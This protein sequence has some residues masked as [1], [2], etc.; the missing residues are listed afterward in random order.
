MNILI[1]AQ[2]QQRRLSGLTHPKHLLEVGGEPILM[3]TL[4]M[5]FDFDQSERAAGRETALTIFGPRGLPQGHGSHVELDAPGSCIVDGIL[6]VAATPFW[7]RPWFRTV[8]LLGDVVWSWAALEAVLADRRPLVFA[9]TPTLSSSEGEVFALAFDNPQEVDNLCRTCPCR[10]DGKRVRSF[11][12]PQGGHLRRLL[13]WAQEQQKRQMAPLHEV[14]ADAKQTWHPDL[15]LPIADW[16]DDVDTP[17]DVARLPE[18]ARLAEIEERQRG[19]GL[20]AAQ[21]AGHG[22]QVGP[23]GCGLPS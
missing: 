1:M 2:G 8:I 9:G 10:L 17:E 23:P 12:N 11:M 15:Y 19:A 18:L 22:G 7:S 21:P 4:R 13:W 6:A 5:L 14:R 3:R 20:T 16:T